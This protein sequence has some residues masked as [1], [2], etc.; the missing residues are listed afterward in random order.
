MFHAA[1]D[2]TN[3][4]LHSESNSFDCSK[5]ARQIFAILLTS[6]VVIIVYMGH[7]NSTFRSKF[8]FPLIMEP[9][10]LRSAREFTPLP[11]D[12][13]VNKSG[14]Y[15]SL[16]PSGVSGSRRLGNMLFNFAA[17]L[18]VAKLTGRRVTMI[19]KHH[20]GWLDNVFNVSI[21]RV[22]DIEREICPCHSLRVLP[23]MIY[24]SDLPKLASLKNVFPGKSILV[25]GF[26]QS[27][28]YTVGVEAELRH[29]LRPHESLSKAVDS[30]LEEIVPKRW[31]LDPSVIHERVVIH[32]RVGDFLSKYVLDGGF[33]IPQLPYFREAMQYIVNNVTIPN[34]TTGRRRHPVHRDIGIDR[35]VSKVA[36]PAV[37][38]GWYPKSDG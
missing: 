19:R 17:M 27:W 30:Y 37:R 24:D 36:R 1:V 22:D 9:E 8:H 34:R 10:S 16:C 28:K 15:V 23:P 21:T 14:R 25:C 6:C 7:M 33:P 26:T 5:D 38:G 31:L 29:H 18:H 13:N 32:I 35:L 20:L 4:L 11:E 3:V 12:S 2:T